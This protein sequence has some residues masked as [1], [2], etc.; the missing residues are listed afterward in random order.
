MKNKFSPWD[1]V[2]EKCG[3]IYSEEEINEMTFAEVTE[4][5]NQEN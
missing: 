3:H 4:I 5:L 2:S 1:L